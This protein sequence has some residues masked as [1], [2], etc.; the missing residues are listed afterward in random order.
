MRAWDVAGW[1]RVR[2]TALAGN[3]VVG[4][5]FFDPV[6]TPMPPFIVSIS[7]SLDGAAQI[8]VVG[9]KGS[10]YRLESSGDLMSWSPLSTNVN[11]EGTVRFT[12]DGASPTHPIRFYRIAA[13]LR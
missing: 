8:V 13:P 2:V 4:G 7:L 9:T 6:G 1:V 3:A 12:D 10:T 11:I 5:V